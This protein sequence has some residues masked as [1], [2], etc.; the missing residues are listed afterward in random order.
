L[1]LVVALSSLNVLPDSSF[2]LNMIS[3]VAA[4]EE[5]EGEA[6]MGEM[7]DLPPASEET[8]AKARELVRKMVASRPGEGEA[9][10]MSEEMEQE[11]DDL[12]S[13]IPEEQ[14]EKI[15]EEEMPEDMKH[16]GDEHDDEPEDEELPEDMMGDEGEEI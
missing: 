14:L 4:Q 6:E 9:P 3:P 5:A 15:F 16:G 10:E 7:K 13:T 11:I 1:S 12:F 8:L 2:G